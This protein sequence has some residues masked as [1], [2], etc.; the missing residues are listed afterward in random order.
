MSRFRL[1]SIILTAIGFGFFLNLPPA[2][3]QTACTNPSP[4]PSGYAAPCSVLSLSS[5]SIQSGGPLSTTLTPSGGNQYVWGTIYL[6]NGSAWEPL[7]VSSNY[8][9][10]TT[11]YTIPA[12]DLSSLSQGTYYIASW[13]WTW[14]QSQSCYTGPGSSTCNT[15]DW[16]AQEFSVTGGGGGTNCTGPWSDTNPMPAT[17]TFYSENP[18]SVTT[19]RLPAD[20]MSHL[21][22]GGDTMALNAMTGGSGSPTNAVE[23]W[24]TPGSD[25]LATPLFY[26][27]SSDPYFNFPTQSGGARGCNYTPSITIGNFHA[28]ANT[29]YTNP[30]RTDDPYCNDG[31]VRVWD[32]ATGAL[33][34]GY[35][36]EQSV[37]P[38]TPTIGPGGSNSSP[39]NFFVGTG[40]GAAKNGLTDQ[41]WG[42][43]YGWLNTQGAEGS[44]NLA[45]MA[46]IVRSAEMVG[47]QIDHALVLDISCVG[48]YGGSATVFPDISATLWACTHTANMPPAGALIFLDYTDAQIAAMNI[49]QWEK[50]LVT[51][52]AHYGGYVSITARE[53]G[54]GVAFQHESGLP[55][56]W[57]TGG[58]LTTKTT[59]GGVTGFYVS[60]GTKDPVFNY[61]QSQGIVCG[62]TS[63]TS[64]CKYT[65]EW[66]GNIPL[67]NGTDV[68]Q[69]I[70]MAAPC[71]AEGYANQSGGCN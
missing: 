50:T 38:P 55:Y 42:S 56:Q 59:S 35:T 10:A 25:D 19:K 17:C 67:V 63:G 30:W 40:C 13:D 12:S 3:A 61:L 69:H 16:R 15:G 54:A 22:T 58:A 23:V 43:P 11:N 27:Q 21:A 48:T 66:L 41:D 64:D 65:F 20:V 45:P 57:S 18:N 31:N 46:G 60:G 52:M 44:A 28:P 39:G 62:G 4:I 2:S 53:G 6:Y 32:Q 8:L 1:S 26:A 33:V 70:H 7:V 24:A 49:P 9:T 37:S 29:P 68:T 51:A 14:N 5:Y 71:I 34:G 36:C 47:G